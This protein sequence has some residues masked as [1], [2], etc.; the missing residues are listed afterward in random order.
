MYYVVVSRPASTFPGGE[1]GLKGTPMVD[2]RML[3]WYDKRIPMQL[4][5]QMTVTLGGESDDS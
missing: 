3:D 2:F 1:N 5:A 4:M